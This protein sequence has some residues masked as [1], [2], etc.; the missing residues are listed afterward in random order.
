VRGDFFC[1]VNRLTSLIGC[2]KSLLCF[3]C[4]DNKIDTFE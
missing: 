3:R 4:E 2:P 1:R